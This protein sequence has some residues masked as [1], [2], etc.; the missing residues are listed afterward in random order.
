[1]LMKYQLDNT[2]TFSGLLFEMIILCFFSM[3]VDFCAFKLLV[4]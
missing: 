2:F 1:M 4:P 3:V